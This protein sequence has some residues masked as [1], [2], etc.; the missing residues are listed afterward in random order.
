MY[1]KRFIVFI[2]MM[3]ILI[4]CH[5]GEVFKNSFDNGD[6]TVLL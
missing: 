6:D 4:G 5:N 1:V 3:I 2:G